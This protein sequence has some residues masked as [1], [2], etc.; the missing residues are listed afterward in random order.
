[1]KVIHSLVPRL[2]HSIGLL[3]CS[4][5]TL[6]EPAIAAGHAAIGRGG[7]VVDDVLIG[8]RCRSDLDDIARIES[9]PQFDEPR[10]VGLDEL[11]ADDVTASPFDI[12]HRRFDDIENEHWRHVR[13][14]GPRIESFVEEGWDQLNEAARDVI[15]GV[16]EPEMVW[17]L[18]LVDD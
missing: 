9:L 6:F 4:L 10:A 5:I 12:A 18:Q 11:C 15:S 1:V 17:R 8:H 7:V 3:E 2:E 16:W 13:Q 14:I